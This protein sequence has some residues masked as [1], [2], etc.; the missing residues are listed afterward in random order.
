MRRILER[1]VSFIGAERMRLQQL[2]DG[3]ISDQKRKEINQ[4][5]NILSAFNIIEKAQLHTE[6]WIFPIQNRNTEINN[7]HLETRIKYEIANKIGRCLF[8][9]LSYGS[10]NSKWW[11]LSYCT[12]TFQLL[13]IIVLFA[14]YTNN[15]PSG[16]LSWPINKSQQ[17]TTYD[18]VDDIWSRKKNHN[19]FKVQLW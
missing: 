14:L 17:R 10:M 12:W 7:K 2:L 15:C 5:L 8:L 1:D 18:N 19:H 13:M 11:T 4:K 3:K 9:F 16:K 6:L